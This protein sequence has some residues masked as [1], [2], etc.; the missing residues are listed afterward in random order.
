[1]KMELEETYTGEYLGGYESPQSSRQLSDKQADYVQKLDGC[2]SFKDVF[3]LV[4]RSVK[5]SLNLE[6]TGLIL[7]LQDLPLK[8]GAY[9]PI[10]TNGIIMNRTLLEGVVQTAASK[11]EVNSF[12]YH[13]LLHEYLHSLGQIDEQ[14]VKEL[15]LLV[16][17]ETFGQDHLATRMASDGPWTYMR[18][19]PFYAPYPYEREV[20]IVRDF[21][22]PSYRYIS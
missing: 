18:L 10:G 13:I 22:T 12:V 21:E 19:D 5:E 20:K 8:V 11:R 4:K 6:R 14:R 1:M 7:Y 3:S 16:S 17:Q 15:T 2:Q 9:H